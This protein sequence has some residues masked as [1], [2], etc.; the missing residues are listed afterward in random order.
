[1]W[2]SWV[3]KLPRYFT[4]NPTGPFRFLDF[5]PELRN[6]VYRFALS[7]QGK[8]AGSR[9]DN[10]SRTPSPTNAIS[11]ALPKHDKYN[12]ATFKPPP[13]TLVSKQVRQ[14]SLAH[15]FSENNF[16]LTVVSNY[17]HKDLLSN[18]GS[19]GRRKQMKDEKSRCGT[20]GFKQLVRTFMKTAG[21]STVFKDVTFKVMKV[22]HPFWIKEARYREIS[23]GRVAE[24][25]L[26]IAADLTLQNDTMFVPNRL[27]VGVPAGGDSLVEVCRKAV[28][29]A[30]DMTAREGF[31]GFT[32]R[33]LS[34]IARA[35]RYEW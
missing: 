12:I 5:P 6:N 9:P 10:T 32:L 19:Y 26:V 31:K 28:G 11:A 23:V 18:G 27:A 22:A 4:D 24:I 21:E 3:R 15:F 8:E 16:F 29:V 30:S 1:M 34:N 7:R 14:E 13:L 2:L 35:L 17:E 20:L 25:R 33:D